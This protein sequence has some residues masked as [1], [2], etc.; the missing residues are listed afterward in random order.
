MHDTYRTFV[1]VVFLM[2][3]LFHSQTVMAEDAAIGSEKNRRAVID[4]ISGGFA[5]F[6]VGEDERVMV[7]DIKSLT[8]GGQEGD[9]FLLHENGDFVADPA[10]TEKRKKDARSRLEMLRGK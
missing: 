1:A 5:T 8:D 4:K 2:M 6:L 3:A 10:V 9:W 7:V